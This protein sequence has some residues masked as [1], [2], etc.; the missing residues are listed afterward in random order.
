MARSAFGSSIWITVTV[1]EDIS[2]KSD[3][4]F[5]FQITSVPELFLNQ[6]NTDFRTTKKTRK[7]SAETAQTS[8]KNGA[9]ATWRARQNA[10]ALHTRYA[11][12]VTNPESAS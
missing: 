11:F 6:H 4:L 12:G 1:N 2:S 10:A 8:T 5:R 7:V 3:G 9:A